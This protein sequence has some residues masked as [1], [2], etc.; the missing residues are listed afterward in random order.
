[1]IRYLGNNEFS[2]SYEEAKVA[3]LPVPYEATVSY[4]KGTGM[5]PDAILDAS[6]QVELY[7]EQTGCEPY[8]IGVATLPHLDLS[9]IDHER[10]GEVITPAVSKVLA[11][12]K[13]PLVLGGEHSITPPVVEAVQK[14]FPDVTVVQFDAHADLRDS[15]E[16]SK[17]SHACAMARVREIVKDAVQIGIRNLS[18]PEAKLAREKQYKIFYAHQVHHDKDWIKKAVDVIKSE[19]V[20]ITF[21][22][23]GFDSTLMPA[24]GTPEPGGIGWYDAVDFMNELFAKKKVVGMD[25]VELAP[26][27]NLHACD[28]LAA[29]LGY[30]AI[31]YLNNSLK[32]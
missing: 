27:A 12:G 29:K 5:G 23:D 22:L 24:T 4:G 7:D 6:T 2:P 18:E 16:G 19:E 25:I 11:D 28:F 1:M 10:I 8:R 3:V 15:Y 14:K 32:I 26:I 9:G 20:Y 21:D 30:K 13:W 17:M 31:A